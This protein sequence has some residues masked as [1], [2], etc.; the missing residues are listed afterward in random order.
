MIEAAF[1][2]VK[3]GFSGV[4]HKLNKSVMR[5]NPRLNA[6]PRL[7]NRAVSRLSV[8]TLFSIFK[9]TPS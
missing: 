6:A 3:R 5:K 8:D 4:Y 9:V 2:P 7:N 1:R